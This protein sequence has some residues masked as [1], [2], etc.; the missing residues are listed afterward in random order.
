M[1]INKLTNLFLLTLA[2]PM[3]WAGG[4][5]PVGDGL[6]Y[7]INAMYGTTG[8]TIAT[9]AVML[10]GLLCLGQVFRWIVLGYT[11]MGI[12]IIFG[13]GSIVNSIVS[14]IHTT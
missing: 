13:A 3:A 6:N 8:V 7:F 14:L 5:T 10:V 2:S 1:K 11:I 4:E 9:L 12:S